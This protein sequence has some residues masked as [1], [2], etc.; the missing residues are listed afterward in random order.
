MD[1]KDESKDYIT[2]K[3]S[4]TLPYFDRRKTGNDHLKTHAHSDQ[5]MSVVIETLWRMTLAME[6]KVQK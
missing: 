5:H 1:I 4:K 3:E 6:A 2:S